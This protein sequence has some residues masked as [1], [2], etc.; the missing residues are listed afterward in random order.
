MGYVRIIYLK[1]Q[2]R[3]TF[4]LIRA[5]ILAETCLFHALFIINHIADALSDLS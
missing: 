2:I 1:Q 5:S 4:E 3:V